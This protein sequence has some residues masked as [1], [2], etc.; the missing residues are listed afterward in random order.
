MIKSSNFSMNYINFTMIDTYERL[1]AWGVGG[2]PADIE[3]GFFFVSSCSSAA[4]AK[5][6]KRTGL[7]L[8]SRL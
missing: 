5:G 7:P 1:A 4:R 2:E 3:R 6:G 8:K